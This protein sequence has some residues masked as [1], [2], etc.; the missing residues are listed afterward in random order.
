MIWKLYWE[1]HLTGQGGK[2]NFCPVFFNY[3]N[4][5]TA[6]VPYRTKEIGVRKT[7]GEK[8]YRVYPK[9]CVFEE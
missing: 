7:L 9:F 5:S 4:L 3:I 6:Q 2:I 1:G 8:S